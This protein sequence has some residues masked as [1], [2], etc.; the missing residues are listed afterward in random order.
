MKAVKAAQH[1]ASLLIPVVL[2]ITV[3]AFAAVVAATQSGGDVQATSAAA[4]SIEAL[5]LAE[6]GVERA[7]KR[8][9]SGTACSALGETITDLSSLGL[10]GRTLSVSVGPSSNLDFN[11]AALSGTQCRIEVAAQIDRSKVLRTVQAII[12]L[13]SLAAHTFNAPAGAGAPTGWTGGAYDYTGGPDPSGASPAACSRAA[14]AVRARSGG[15]TASSAGTAT[16]SFTVSLPAT[17]LVD[18]DY[19]IIQVGNSGSTACNSSAGGGAC[20]GAADAT[21]PGGSDG[22]ICMTMRDTPGG[23]TYNSTTYGVEVSAVVANTVAPAA[24]TPTTQQSPT[25]AVYTPC[26][27][28]YNVSGAAV[29]PQQGTVRFA[30]AGSGNVA[31]DRV[32]FNL[33]IPGGAQGKELWVDNITFTLGGGGVAMPKLWR[34]CSASACPAV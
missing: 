19:R 24:C 31:F 16:A 15:S 10:T 3:A 14:Y 17:I 26:S 27:T 34:D 28:K 21:S 23:A 32:G 18:F 20:P 9:A 4:D 25:P 13:G 12:D 8:F 2:V 22:Q 7:M 29:L 6:T 30:L 5:V 1:G 11:L 33:Y